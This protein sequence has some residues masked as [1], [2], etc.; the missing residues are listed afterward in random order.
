M[1]QHPYNI[2]PTPQCYKKEFQADGHS[3]RIEGKLLIE[4]IDE[5]RLPHAYRT[6][7]KR[8]QYCGVTTIADLIKPLQEGSKLLRI[9]PY[10]ERTLRL[11]RQKE[12]ALQA[13]KE[14]TCQEDP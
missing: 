10:S 2:K 8:V 6:L 14:K 12:K 1:S 3:I 7:H 11:H 4:I 9:K 5:Y 13:A